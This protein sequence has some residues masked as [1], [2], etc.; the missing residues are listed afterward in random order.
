MHCLLCGCT[1]SSK[2]SSSNEGFDRTEI[3][4]LSYEMQREAIAHLSPKDKMTLWRYK[5][6]DVLKNWRLNPQEQKTVSKIYSI[7]SPA[8]FEDGAD[9]STLDNLGESLI[10]DYSWSEARLHFTLE[11]IL[12][13]EELEELTKRDRQIASIIAEDN[14]LSSLLHE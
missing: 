2:K 9:T 13:L 12:T 14:Y 10:N 5:L 4:S 1:M 3:T 7:L 6:E 11:T 8:L